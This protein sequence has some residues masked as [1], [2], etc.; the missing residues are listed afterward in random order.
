MRG[1]KVEKSEMDRSR[2]IP[3]EIILYHLEDIAVKIE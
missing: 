1:S 3:T 2:R